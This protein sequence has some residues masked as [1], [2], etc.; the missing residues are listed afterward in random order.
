MMDLGTIRPSSSSWSSPLH[1]VPKQIPGDWRPC[2]DY[3]SLNYT[4]VPDRYPIPHIR[5]FTTTLHGNTVFSK[6]DLVRAY[7]QIPVAPEDV[8]KTAITTPFGLFE[9]VRMPFGLRNAAQTFQRFV[10]QV[11]QGLTFAYAYIDDILIAG[12]SQEEHIQHLETVFQHLSDYGLIINNKLMCVCSNSLHFLGHYIDVNGIHP[13]ETKVQ[14]ITEFPKL[15]SMKQLRQFLGLVNFY[16][17]FIPNC[18][19]I[20]HPLHTLLKANKLIWNEEV[21]KAFENIKVCLAK[22]TMLSHPK[23]G[24]PTS[25]MSDASNTAVGAVLQQFV[26]G[27][28]HPISYFSH[29]LSPAETKYSTFDRELLAIYLAIKHFRHFIEGREFH[30]GLTISLSHSQLLLILIVIHLVKHVNLTLFHNS[31]LILDI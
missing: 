2:G 25:I 31:L 24:A 22:A 12:S 3:R 5:D 4:T 23:L 30:I 20:V 10:D 8:P 29:K 6:I 26:D 7:H 11:L 15:Q 18:A 17:R 19:H 1:M 9:F 16:H 28:W 13:I 21:S 14:A 27:V